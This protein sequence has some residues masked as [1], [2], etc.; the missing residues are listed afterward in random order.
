MN[1]YKG[2]T[3]P[4]FSK[5]ITEDKKESSLLKLK[6]EEIGKTKSKYS[7]IYADEWD[8]VSLRGILNEKHK[9]LYEG[10]SEFQGIHVIEATDIRMYLDEQLQFSSL[11]ERIYH[12]AFVHIPMSLTQT[13][14]R[15]LILGG[16]DG[17]ALREVLKYSDV[18]NVD[19]VDLDS[20]VL[21]VARNVPELAA[22]NNRAF[23]DNRVQV[24]AQDALEYLK[25]NIKTYDIMI[26]DFPDPTNEVLANLYTVE[27][28]KKLYNHLSDEGMIVCQSNSPED[29]PEVF[30]SIGLTMDAAGFYTNGY[31]TLV[32]SFGD[33]G[34]QLG[35]KKNHSKGLS[36]ITINVP[37]RTLPKNPKSLFEFSRE[38]LS[39]KRRGVINT[40]G[41]LVLHKVF[42]DSL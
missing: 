29:S 40:K 10:K 18:K 38:I 2:E 16:G 22:L 24:Y 25:T 36:N 23:F 33:W 12:E 5:K 21:H 41:H 31:H 26:I 39:Y 1:M 13:H 9:K 27:V 37:H 8:R 20:T 17:L 35:S 32:P 34:F 28:F 11:D 14:K 19:L 4:W 15:V 3:T 7:E 30:W 42:K 6:S